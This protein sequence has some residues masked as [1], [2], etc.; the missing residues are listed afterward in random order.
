MST[1]LAGCAG[2]TAAASFLLEATDKV[3]PVA[4]I[5]ISIVAG[6]TASLLTYMTARDILR[7][8]FD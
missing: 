5:S 8:W 2:V 1:L 6:L 3:G 4:L 7:R